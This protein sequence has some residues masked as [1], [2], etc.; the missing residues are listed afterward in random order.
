MDNL[1]L[2]SPLLLPEDGPVYEEVLPACIKHPLLLVCDH[3]SARIPQRLGELGLSRDELERHIGV[4][5]GAAEVTRRLALKLGSPALLTRFSRLVVD[6]N[7]HPDNPTFI[8]ES[9]DTT[10]IPGNAALTAA[11]RQSRLD[12]IFRPYQHAV[13]AQ[14][15]RLEKQFDRT[16]LIAIHSF[17]PRLRENDADRPW[18]IGV[19]WN[20]DP[21]TAARLIA[22]LKA[23]SSL[24]IGDNQPYSMLKYS[25]YTLET[26]SEGRHTPS[27]LIEIRQNELTSEG[28]LEFYASL[29]AGFFRSIWPE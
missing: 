28:Q 15:R 5:A 6:C 7:R 22:H 25:G 10:F 16:G 12:E 14:L 20:R 26:H 19:V 21:V 8:P 4:D 11:Q 3:A 17:T 27:L 24:T 29:L 13:G 2:L 1:S 18:Q 9:S 23:N